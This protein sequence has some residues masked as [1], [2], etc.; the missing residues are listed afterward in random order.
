MAISG[1][2]MIHVVGT[3]VSLLT[4]AF[5]LVRP[6]RDGIH[7]R[8]GYAYCGAMVI[9]NLSALVIY[10][11]SGGFNIFHAFALYSL[12]NVGMALRPMLIHPRPYQW[13]R[14]HYQWVAWSYVGLSAA[15]VTEALLRI[16]GLPG[17]LSPMVATPPVIILG[18]VLIYRFAPPLRPPRPAP[19]A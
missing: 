9:G 14:I 2:G 10:K 17:W 12:F 15:A 5:Q 18:W 6:Q 19:T 13:R 8:I 1:V 3:S 16:V 11:F 4:G 7:R